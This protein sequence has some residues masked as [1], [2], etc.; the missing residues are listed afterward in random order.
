MPKSKATTKVITQ[1]PSKFKR[2]VVVGIDPCT[3][4][5]MAWWDSGEADLG[6]QTRA[7]L[8]EPSIDHPLDVVEDWKR[9]PLCYL[10]VIIECP[11]GAHVPRFMMAAKTSA[12]RWA[13]YFRDSF[14]RRHQTI[15]VAPQ[16]WQSRLRAYRPGGRIPAG[17]MDYVSFA[18]L[19]HPHLWQGVKAPTDDQAAAMCILEYGRGHVVF[20][21]SF[22]KAFA[23]LDKMAPVRRDD[24]TDNSEE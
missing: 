17:G 16:T 21:L 2:L 5:G 4:G 22:T 18:R 23:G 8:G 10:V 7:V 3:K 14:S 12:L 20:P 1:I 15:R 13:A 24:V 9:D 11:P 6:V 19:M